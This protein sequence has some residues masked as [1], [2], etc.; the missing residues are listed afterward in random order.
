MD[1]QEN[2][3]VFLP[4]AYAET[5]I[6][7]KPAGPFINVVFAAE[8][9]G[10]RI[11]VMTGLLVL[12]DDVSAELFN[13]TNWEGSKV[14]LG[15]LPV[16]IYKAKLGMQ[17]GCYG[18]ALETEILWRYVG[19]DLVV[20]FDSLKQLQD[21][22]SYRRKV[23][24]A[25]M[26]EHISWQKEDELPA[27][28][29][30]FWDE[31]GVVRTD[32]DSY[33]AVEDLFLGTYEYKMQCFLATLLIHLRAA[34]QVI[35]KGGEPPQNRSFDDFMQGCIMDNYPETLLMSAGF[36]GSAWL[37]GDWGYIKNTGPVI[38]LGLE[39]ENIIYLGGCF[40][41]DFNAFKALA[42]FWGHPGGTKTLAGWIEEVDLMDEVLDGSTELR[43][44]RQTL[45]QP[46]GLQVKG[47]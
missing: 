2:A 21:D 35:G 9:I 46:F 40:N 15:G 41:K 27:F 45:R 4:A 37:P 7:C 33:D 28:N 14:H 39:G 31:A 30:L 8:Y 24:D 10:L 47:D 12:N 22:I 36:H 1:D 25:I 38:R 23:V 43:D 42:P 6:Q 32:V 13:I 29:P 18:T 26:Q 11:P 19:S 17:V 3:V 20:A 5:H 34:S 16:Y 44:T